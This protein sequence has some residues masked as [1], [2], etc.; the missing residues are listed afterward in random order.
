M[1]G[2]L[3][4][5]IL[6]DQQIQC[7]ADLYEMT[8]FDLIRLSTALTEQAFKLQMSLIA[9]KVEQ[10]KSKQIIQSAADEFKRKVD[11]NGK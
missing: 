3:T 5:S 6:P 9:K 1:K 11:N 8:E 2:S 7:K 10:A 4:F